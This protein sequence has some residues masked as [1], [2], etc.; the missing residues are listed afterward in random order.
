MEFRAGLWKKQSAK[1]T[2]FCTGKIKI[3]TN[4]YNIMLF[5]NDK[6]G[7]EKAPDF[8]LILRDNTNTIEKQEPVQMTLE[9][10]SSNGLDDSLF[11][12]FGNQIEID[13]DDIPF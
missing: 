2:K 13:P 11:E 9:N 4:E 6:K 5:N 10:K 3:G 12:E 8:N 1:G 7:N